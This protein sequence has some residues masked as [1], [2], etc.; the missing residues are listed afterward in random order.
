MFCIEDFI[1]QCKRCLLAS[2]ILCTIMGMLLKFCTLHS[3]L[4]TY[5][6][7]WHKVDL[8]IAL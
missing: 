4:Y 7:N 5:M 8:S 3:T 1:Q 6:I 2:S